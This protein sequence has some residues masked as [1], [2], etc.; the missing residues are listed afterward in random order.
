MNKIKTLIFLYRYTFYAHLKDAFV[1]Q[2]RILYTDTDSFFFHFFVK[3]LAKEINAH[4][5]LPDV[6]DFSEISNDHVY[7]LGR[8]NADLHAGEVGYLKDETKSKPLVEFVS[9]RPKMYS[10]TVC[11]ASELIPVV[12]YQ[13]HI[14]RWQ[15]VWRAPKSSA[16]STRITCACTMVEP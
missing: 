9:L 13:I 6:F 8:N 7:N 15:R 2:V 16:S 1:K 3:D 14:R 11:D 12:N 10:F 5:H 4:P